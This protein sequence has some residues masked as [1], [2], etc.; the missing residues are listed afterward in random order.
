MERERNIRPWGCWLSIALTFFSMS[1]ISEVLMVTVV[2]W[3]LPDSPDA[4]V[5][6]DPP[7]PPPEL[8]PLPVAVSKPDFTVLS[9]TWSSPN[10]QTSN[11][12]VSK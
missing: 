4:P 5:D 2:L 3:L 7:P 10:A 8:L 6:E 12:L 9:M 1:P 11:V